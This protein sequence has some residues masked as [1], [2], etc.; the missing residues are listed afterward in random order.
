[1]STVLTETSSYDATITV[2]ASGDARTASSVNTAFQSLTNRSKYLYD[3]MPNGLLVGG[4]RADCS[5]G[6]TVNISAIKSV[7][8]GNKSYSASAQALTNSSLEGGGSF[9]NSTWYYVYCYV[10][11]GSLAFQIS[12]TAPEASLTWK[13]GVTTHRYLRSFRTNSSGT[14]YRFRACGGRVIY[15][16]SAHSPG[17]FSVLAASADGSFTD[18]NCAGFVPPHAR[19]ITLFANFQIA[20]DADGQR[21][22]R[23]RTNGDTSSYF[24]MKTQDKIAQQDAQFDIETDSSQIFEYSIV[25]SASPTNTIQLDID[26]V[27]YSE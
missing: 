16:R 14:V 17:T 7:I 21:E 6:A 9:A 13:T 23:Y 11:A 1:M 27:G 22:V 24:S 8:I 2:P 12:T 3:H 26:I 15:R 20:D 25:D 19:L 4:D 18:V 10:S 5:D